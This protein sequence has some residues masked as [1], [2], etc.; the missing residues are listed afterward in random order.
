MAEELIA[1]LDW[2]R[3][4]E[5]SSLAA[6]ELIEKGLIWSCPE[7]NE[8]EDWADPEIHHPMSDHTWEEIERALEDR[9]GERHADEL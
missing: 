2:S 8:R 3:T 4:M 6:E 5:V 9:T 1:D 7:C